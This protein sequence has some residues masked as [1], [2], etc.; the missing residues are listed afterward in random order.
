LTAARAGLRQTA[1]A[2]T[3][4]VSLRAVSKWVANDKVGGLLAFYGV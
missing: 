1:A 4:V 2:R 3:Y